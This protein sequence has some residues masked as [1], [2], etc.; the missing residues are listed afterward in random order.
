MSEI[1]DKILPNEASTEF[2]QICNFWSMEFQEKMLLRF[3]DLYQT[4]HV[5]IE[6]EDILND[7]SKAS[8]KFLDPFLKNYRVPMHRDEGTMFGKKNR[9]NG[10][11]NL[12]QF[13]RSDNEFPISFL[14][15]LTIWFDNEPNYFNRINGNKK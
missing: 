14:Q 1:L 13:A 15:I 9:S 6:I 10:K 11:H 5:I 12:N 7:I 8:L 2:N 3:T 4:E